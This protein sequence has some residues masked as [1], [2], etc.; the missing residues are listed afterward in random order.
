MQGGR[1][2]PYGGD[3]LEGRYANYFEIGHN[4][5]EFLLDFGQMYFEGPEAQMHTRIVTSP[6]FAKKLA[7]TLNRALW[8]YEQ[9]HGFVP[10]EVEEAESEARPDNLR[11]LRAVKNPWE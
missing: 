4:A 9:A 7:E 3:T 8:Q 10:D 11:H 5:F 2:G 1:K 6:I